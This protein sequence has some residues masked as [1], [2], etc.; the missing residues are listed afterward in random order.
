MPC[1]RRLDESLWERTQNPWLLLQHVPLERLER[2][3]V[4]ADFLRDLQLLVT[5]A[6]YRASPQWRPAGAD[7]LPRVAYFS[8]EFGLHEA[9]PLYAGGLGI[10]RV[11]T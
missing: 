11:T 9:L 3:A 10:L 4:D 8:M 5:R 1:W 7:R 6:R 2:L